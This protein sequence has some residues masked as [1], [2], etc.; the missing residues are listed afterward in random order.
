M[1]SKDDFKL[2]STPLKPKEEQ[3]DQP[4]DSQLRNFKS[5]IAFN[6][7]TMWLSDLLLV[8]SIFIFLYLQNGSDFKDAEWALPSQIITAEVI[9]VIFGVF[10]LV[11]NFLAAMLNNQ[12]NIRL[13]YAAKKSLVPKVYLVSVFLLI[14]SI[15]FPFIT[16]GSFLAWIFSKLT[17]DP[18]LLLIHN[19]IF[20]AWTLF[21]FVLVLNIVLYFLSRK[22]MSSTK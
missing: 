5:V 4:T 12:K 13:V 15:I 21:L 9:L 16:N 10:I 14:V 8:S 17:G 22:V 19:A 2:T 18:E 1:K 7:I 6:R 20:E 11:F 3:N